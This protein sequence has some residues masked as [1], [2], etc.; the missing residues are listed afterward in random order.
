MANPIYI[1][2]NGVDI[3]NSVDWKTIDCVQVL[4]KENASLKFNVRQNAAN[5][6]GVTV[7]VIGDIVKL[8]DPSGLIFGGTVTEVEAT[9]E[10]LMITNQITVSDWGYLFN[11]TL[12]K[13]NYAADGSRRHRHRHRD[14]TSAR[15]RGSRRTTSSAATSS[16]PPS[17]STISSR[18]KHCSRSRTSI[19]W[20]WYIDANKDI[21]FFL[22]DV[23][24]AVGEGGSAPIVVN[25][26][27][28]SSGSDIQWNSLDIDLN[29][30]NMQNSV[31]V[32]GG[33]YIKTFT[34]ANTIDT[35][36]TDGV[37]QF[38]SVSYSYFAPTDS[39]PYENPI[40]VTLD[41]VAQT[42][43]TANSTDPST[44][45]VLY[46]DQQ[47]WIQFTEGAPGSGQR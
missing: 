25:Q 15:A 43:G 18:R 47:K 22:G 39:N 26:S 11:G 7:P 20:D 5:L 40:I 38:F 34:A 9:I 4:T 44:V 31:Y 1:T 14:D 16:S 41:G 10:G 6:P 3:S 13:K 8:Y 17:N 36:P 12:V 33:M 30:Q 37:R 42:V 28:G 21:H 2:N 29:L 32:I 24:D 46:N 27:G 23:E 19:G 45:Q 35:F